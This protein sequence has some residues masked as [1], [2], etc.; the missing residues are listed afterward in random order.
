MLI[1]L[2]ICATLAHVIEYL[3]PGVLLKVQNALH[4]ML[5]G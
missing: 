4:Q 1:L 5:E 3:A 2:P